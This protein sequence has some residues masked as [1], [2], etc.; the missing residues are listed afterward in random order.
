[1]KEPQHARVAASWLVSVTA[2]AFATLIGLLVLTGWLL[3]VAILKSLSPDWISMRANTA[4]AFVL[5][6]VS[7]T[8]L[9]TRRLSSPRQPVWR[10]VARGCALLVVIIGGLTIAEYLTGLDLGIDQWLFQEPVGA[11]C[12]LDRSGGSRNS[13]RARRPGG[14]WPVA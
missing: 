3:D 1:M 11:P 10:R 14:S 12:A 13:S 2:G 7:L 5:A 8:L 9:D 4:V 6:G